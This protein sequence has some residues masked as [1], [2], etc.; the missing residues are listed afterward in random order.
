M[1]S[2]GRRW[3]IFIPIASIMYMLA[4]CDRTNIAFAITN[5]GIDLNLN[6]ADKGL[7][8]GIFFLGYLILQVP[9]AILA[10]KWSAKKTVF[11]LLILWGIASICTGFVRSKAE[12]LFVRFILGL[13]EGGLQPATLVMLLHWFP[14]KEKARANGFWL[15]CIPFSSIIAAP[16]IGMLLESYSWRNVLI[17]AGLL[18]LIWSVVWFIFMSDSPK[19]KCWWIKEQ[20][21]DYIVSAIEEDKI[22]KNNNQK[23]NNGIDKLFNYKL[24]MLIVAWFLY[25]AGFFGFV[26]WLPE[27]VKTISNGSSATVGFL[28]AIPYIVGLICMIGI[29]VI[30][31]KKGLNK[32]SIF[33]PLTF[34]A[35]C[36]L[37]GQFV[38]DPYIQFLFLCGVAAGLYIHGPF[39]SIPPLVLNSKHLA[40]S[41]GLIGGIGNLGGLCGPYVVG[42]LIDIT[43][44]TLSGFILVSIAIFVCGILLSLVTPRVNK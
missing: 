37:I 27:V 35:L 40:L 38:N 24:I 30:T 39:F 32:L 26:M 1:F 42:F 12:L 15:L 3:L 33:I 16:I 8:T 22:R 6:N 23:I 2:S 21:A 36:L 29:S 13:F 20:E 11:A 9:A 28:T 25:C 7:V 41:L 44:S 5:I 14:Q 10:E 31:D 19:S 17:M 34:C 18:P 4:F 43:N